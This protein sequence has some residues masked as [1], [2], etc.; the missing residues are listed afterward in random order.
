MNKF[1]ENELK[2]HPD[3]SKAMRVLQQVLQQAV[4][5][6][7]EKNSYLTVFNNVCAVVQAKERKRFNATK[8]T[9]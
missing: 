5:F 8:N 3:L 6:S 1:H 2:I 9:F 7:L 4:L